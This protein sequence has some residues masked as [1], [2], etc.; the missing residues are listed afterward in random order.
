MYTRYTC[1]CVCIKVVVYCILQ[2]WIF[3]LHL[4][5]SLSLICNFNSNTLTLMALS[6]NILTLLTLSALLSLVHGPLGTDDDLFGLPVPFLVGEDTGVLF[7]LSS[8]V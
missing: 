7:G 8:A 1:M 4:S 6:P 5:D 3:M 2:G